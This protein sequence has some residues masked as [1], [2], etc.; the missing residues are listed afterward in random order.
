MAPGLALQDPAMRGRT[1]AV[2]KERRQGG[3]GLIACLSLTK[4]PGFTIEMQA[5]HLQS[6]LKEGQLWQNM[7]RSTQKQRF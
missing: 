3:R 5:K 6:S 4:L 2:G 7:L 1:A